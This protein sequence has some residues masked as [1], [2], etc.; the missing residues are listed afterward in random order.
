MLAADSTQAD[1]WRRRALLTMEQQARRDHQPQRRMDVLERLSGLGTAPQQAKARMALLE[2][3]LDYAD[4][5]QVV[6]ELGAML[7]QAGPDDM[8]REEMLY[9]QSRGLLFTGREE[10]AEQRLRQLRDEYPSGRRA[11][12][13]GRLLQQRLD[14]QQRQSGRTQP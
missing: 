9:L 1:R 2:L 5:A 7:E 14:E 10:I 13:A 4:P 11:A 3:Q 8:L 12:E 6:E